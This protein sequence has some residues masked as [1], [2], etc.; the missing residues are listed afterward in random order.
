MSMTRIS[1]R[2]IYGFLSGLFGF[3]GLISIVD[4]AESW[5]RF[6]QGFPRWIWA[7]AYL[8]LLMV[9]VAL[10]FGSD[11]RAGYGDSD[12][13]STAA[14]EP[15]PTSSVSRLRGQAIT[16]R[17]LRPDNR[18]TPVARRKARLGRLLAEGMT[19]RSRMRTTSGLAAYTVGATTESDVHAW[20][21]KVVRVLD[22]DAHLVGVFLA[23]QFRP[24]N[25]LLPSLQSE[26]R[27]CLDDRIQN[28]EKIINELPMN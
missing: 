11:R 1:G 25:M 9:G 6:V 24:I 23:D 12:E 13:P 15:A 14:P 21:D 8:V 16:E 4:D 20:E 3:V 19:L 26:L 10:L 28:L 5:F 17:E 7:V 2:R 27:G 18:A 22:A